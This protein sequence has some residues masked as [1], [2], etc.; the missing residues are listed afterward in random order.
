M[1]DLDLKLRGDESPTMLKEY[2]KVMTKLFNC[3]AGGDDEI[4]FSSLTQGMWNIE[5]Q[6]K[7]SLTTVEHFGMTFFWHRM[8]G[9]RKCAVYIW[10]GDH[11]L[12]VDGY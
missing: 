1:N 7:H 3:M 11:L 12:R 6:L 8:D 10:K 4:Y 9:T 5:A 2:K